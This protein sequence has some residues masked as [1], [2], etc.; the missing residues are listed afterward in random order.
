MSLNAAIH[1]GPKLQRDL[2]AV[3]ARFRKYPVVMV[4]D[5]AETYLRI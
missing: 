2:R 1:Q 4:W 5:V 3:L